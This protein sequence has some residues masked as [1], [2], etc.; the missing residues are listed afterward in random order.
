[1]NLLIYWGSKDNRKDSW[2]TEHHISSKDFA[3]DPEKIP[4]HL[5]YIF[6]TTDCRAALTVILT[7]HQTIERRTKY[8]VQI[9]KSE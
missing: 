8:T 7:T 6:D 2:W 9:Q 3:G 1:M 5:K 4:E